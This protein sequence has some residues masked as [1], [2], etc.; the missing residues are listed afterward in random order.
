MDLWYKLSYFYTKLDYRN[1]WIR[2]VQFYAGRDSKR[3]VD[4]RGL[5]RPEKWLFWMWTAYVRRNRN[6]SFPGEVCKYFAFLKHSLG[7]W[8]FQNCTD[9]K[10]SLG[11]HQTPTVKIADRFKPL[12]ISQRRVN[13]RSLTRSLIRVW[14][15]DVKSE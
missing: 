14:D 12:T 13:H 10:V 6:W 2:E 1:D 7:L 15:F 5:S 9:S 8:K 11:P 4:L 3:K